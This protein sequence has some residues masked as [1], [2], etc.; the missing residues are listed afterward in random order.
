M[1]KDDKKRDIIMSKLSSIKLKSAGVKRKKSGGMDCNPTGYHKDVMYPS[2]YLNTKNTPDLAGKDV[3]DKVILVI[4]AKIVSH[5]LNEDTKSDK[6]ESY[7]LEI[8]RIG[9]A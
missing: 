8:K 3:E 4:E 5:S 6:R 7:D 2:L 1:A 9:V